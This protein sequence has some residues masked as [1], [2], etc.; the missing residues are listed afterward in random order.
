MVAQFR[1]KSERFATELHSLKQRVPVPDY[2]WY[3][4]QTLAAVP[5]ISDLLE[6]VYQEVSDSISDAPVADIGCGDGDLA[7]LFASLGYSVDAIDHAETNYNQMRGVRTLQR[8][9]AL[10]VT[11]YDIDLD[12][13]FTLPRCDY[14]LA[15]FLGTLYHL[16]NPFY[17]LE[18][19]SAAADWCILSTRIAQATPDKRTRI[20]DQPLGYLLGGREAN[21]DPTNYWIFS[22]TGLLRLLERT[23]WIV[24][25]HSRLGCSID[26]DPLNNEADERA[27]VVAKSRTRHPS[28]TVRLLDG[29]YAVED[30]A[31]RWTSK[32]FSLEVTLPDGAH[33][34]A[35]A[36]FLPDAAYS[37]GPVKISCAV[38]GHDAGSITCA[39][40]D[41]KEFRGRF[42]FEALS[43]RLDFTVESLFRPSSDQRELGICVPVKSAQ[44]IPFRVS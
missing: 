19:I 9:L 17:V 18:A 3:P 1:E 16:K 10:P 40:A 8:E 35:L 29:W 5:A 38:S 30:N 24:M 11:A 15:I 42:P 4:H 28:L 22:F 23:G 13:P 41:A 39:S 27:L 20:E 25:G 36:F 33:E 31:F 37:S 34:F 12:A 32:H 26:S 7:L 21:N 14:G 6:P 44:L 43:Y 2:G